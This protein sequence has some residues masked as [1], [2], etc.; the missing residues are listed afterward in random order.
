MRV[1]KDTADKAYDLQADQR[2]VWYNDKEITGWFTAD[3][4]RRVVI[5]E[6]GK[7]LSGAVCIERL[8]DTPAAIVETPP[9][10]PADAGFAGAG[11]VFDKP[12]NQDL[13]QQE[14]A[15]CERLESAGDEHPG[16]PDEGLV[17][18]QIER[19]PEDDTQF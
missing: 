9:S 4:F 1:S 8:A 2:R 7:V 11:L 15:F 16:S 13:L 14:P 10:F 5:L 18:P 17:F 19:L 3:E 6:N 12:V